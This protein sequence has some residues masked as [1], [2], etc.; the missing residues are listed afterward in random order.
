MND[1]ILEINA[2]IIEFQQNLSKLSVMLSHLL[3]QVMEKKKQDEIKALES[4]EADKE[5]EDCLR[6]IEEQGG[7]LEIKI[8][9][10]DDVKKHLSEYLYVESFTNM[11]LEEQNILRE[12]WGFPPRFEPVA[13]THSDIQEEDRCCNE[14]VNG[15]S[16][17]DKEADGSYPDEHSEV[18]CW[19][20]CL[21]TS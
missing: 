11:S 5:A 2:C 19:Q 9:D 3:E 6:V 1:N 8:E 12:L 18:G 4:M 14:E 13:W 17:C 7:K 20:E 16:C 21:T 10:K 15:G